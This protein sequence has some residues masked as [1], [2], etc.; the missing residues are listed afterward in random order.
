MDYDIFANVI[1]PAPD[2]QHAVY[3]AKDFDFRLRKGSKAADAGIAL[4]G[5]NDGFSGKAPDLGA[6]EAGAEKPVYGPRTK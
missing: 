2:K 6:L 5:I 4:P 3:W 1:R